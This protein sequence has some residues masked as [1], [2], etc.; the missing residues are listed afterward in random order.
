MLFLLA[1]MTQN[2]IYYL[3]SKCR[4]VQARFQHTPRPLSDQF[5]QRSEFLERGFSLHAVC[6]TST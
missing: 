4:P 5:R 2:S 1:P 6:V 3:S